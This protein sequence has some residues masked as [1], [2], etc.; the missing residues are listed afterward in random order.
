MKKRIGNIMLAILL[1]CVA[2]GRTSGQVTNTAGWFQPVFSIALTGGGSFPAGN[3]STAR[4]S[5]PAA[6][7]AGPGYNLGVSGTWLLTAHFGVGALASMHQFG[8]RGAQQMVEGYKESFAVDSATFYSK[9]TNHSINILIGPYYNYPLSKRLSIDARLLCGIVYATLAG[10]EVFIEGQ[11]EGTFAQKQSSVVAFGAQAGLG[12]G[13][14]LAPHFR[15]SLNADY[16]YSRPDFTI[17]NS[18]RNNTA[19]RLLTAYHQ[20]LAGVNTNV[21][22]AWLLAGR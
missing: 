6:G 14:R 20:P 16:Y 4:Y 8:F 7:F 9:G 17:S 22:V 15:L 2:I 12:L 13:Y 1:M 5:D 3:F 10:N 21:T 19:G 11:Q 18:N